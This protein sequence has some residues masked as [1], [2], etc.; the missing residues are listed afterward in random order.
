MNIDNIVLKTK[1]EIRKICTESF[2]S[3][4]ETKIKESTKAITFYKFKT[5]IILEPYLNMNLNPKHKICISRFRLSNHTLMIEKG[6]HTNI[7]RNN[8]VC[9]F[10]ENEIEDEVHFL[11]RCPLYTKE[12]NFITGICEST[13]LNFQDLS[14]EQKFI[15]VMTNEGNDIIRIVA[16]FITHSLLLREKIITY[17][18][19]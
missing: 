13:C 18:Y 1:K 11:I 8:R 10:C 14:D 6:R 3:F 12:R 19:N 7:D 15:F 2:D 4:W 16:K 17:F 9:Y 5:S